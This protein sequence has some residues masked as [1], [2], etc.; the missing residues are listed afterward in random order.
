MGL[1]LLYGRAFTMSETEIP[2]APPVAIIDEVLAKKLWPEGDALG[3]RIEWA[4]RTVPTASAV[5]SGACSTRLVR[6][7]P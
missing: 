2:G 7:M 1:P 6:R 5:C 3:Q 4:E